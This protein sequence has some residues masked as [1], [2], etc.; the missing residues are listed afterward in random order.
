MVSLNLSPPNLATISAPLSLTNAFTDS[1]AALNCGVIAD[2]LFGTS[3]TGSAPVIPITNLTQLATYFNAQPDAVG[4]AVQ[5]EEVERFAAFNSTN[6]AFTTNS[7]ALTAALEAGGTFTTVPLTTNAATTTPGV[8]NFASTTGVQVG[9][10]VAIAFSTPTTGI[11]VTAVTS[12]TV[13]ISSALSPASGTQCEFLPV[14]PVTCN[15]VT[16]GNTLTVPAGVPAGLVPGMFYG[17]ITNGTFG[18]VRAVTASGTTITLDANVTVTAGNLVMFSP[19]VASAQI[20]SKA[21]YQPGKN[22]ANVLAFELTCTIPQSAAAQNG[23]SRGAWPAFWLYSKTSDG[24]S[25]DASEIDIFEFFCS[26]TAGS[27]GFTSNIHGGAYNATRFQRTVGSG[28]SKWDSSGFYR[29]GTDYGL[30]QHKFQLLWTQDK[31]YR[32]IDGQLIIVNDFLWSSNDSAQWSC[33]LAC[34]SWIPAF[35][36][37]FFYPSST[38][39]FPFVFNINEVKIWQG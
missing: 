5:N 36:G 4:T 31:V 7:L 20:W 24:F 30:A 1:L 39:Q 6:H 33:D 37:I 11:K 32:F 9:M 13:T 18:I 23:A 15:A 21:G 38:A 8:L 25:F 28:N 12:T 27:N 34:G 35:L 26:L 16:A 10:M 3:A 22:G 29:P 19:P 2:Y 14:Y 17:N